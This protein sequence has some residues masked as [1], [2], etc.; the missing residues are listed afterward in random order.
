MTEYGRENGRKR[1]ERMTAFPISDMELIK[2]MGGEIKQV[3]CRCG[4]CGSTL[5]GPIAVQDLGGG[6]YRPISP[7]FG[8]MDAS[9]TLHHKE[10]REEGLDGEHNFFLCQW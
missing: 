8:G 7:T 10:T 6:F 2:R 5:S 1:I 4:K 3:T 9:M